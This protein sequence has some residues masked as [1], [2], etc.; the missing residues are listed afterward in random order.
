MG[1]WTLDETLILQELVSAYGYAWN[2]IAKKLRT[3]LHRSVTASSIRNRVQRTVFRENVKRKQR[4]STCGEFRRGH[5]C[6]GNVAAAPAI[7]PV[8]EA[9]MESVMEAVMEPVMEAVM[10]AVMEP[11]M[12]AVMEPVMDPVMK[13]VSIEDYDMLFNR[14]KLHRESCVVSSASVAREMGFDNAILLRAHPCASMWA[15]AWAHETLDECRL[16]PA[17]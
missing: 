9:V 8:M 16:K 11:V 5:I 6:K 1:T 15:P 12:E 10:E 13:P 3:R 17:S 2:T 4:C 14:Y 7:K